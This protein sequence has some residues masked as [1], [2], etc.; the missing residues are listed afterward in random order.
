MLYT[1]LLIAGAAL[2]S[3]SIVETP[4]QRDLLVAVATKHWLVAIEAESI[5]RTRVYPEATLVVIRP[6]QG[7]PGAARPQ[8]SEVF[9]SFDC[10]ARSIR[11]SIE[12]PHTGVSYRRVA[13]PSL[14]AFKSIGRNIEGRALAR[15]ICDRDLSKVDL[16]IGSLEELKRKYQS[17]FWRDSVRSASKKA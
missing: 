9:S 2:T 8:M 11:K 10:T 4:Q 14:G 16:F 5:V 13:Q 1:S 15:V 17:A 7:R 3:G 6:E 12:T